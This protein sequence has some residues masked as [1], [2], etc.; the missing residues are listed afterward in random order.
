MI[1][2][3]YDKDDGTQL[4][5][6]YMHL[7]QI[8][9]KEGQVVQ[10]GQ[11]IG[12]SGNT[13]RSTGPH[14]HFET[15]IKDASGKIE[16]FNPIHYLA[17]IEGRTSN[18]TPLLR[19]GQDLLA[20]ERSKYSPAAHPISQEDKAQNLLANI[21]QSNDPTK[22]L[23]YLMSQNSENGMDNNKDAFSELISTLFSAALVMAAKIKANEMQAVVNREARLT[24]NDEEKT[25]CQL[26]KREREK[27][28]ASKLHVLASTIFETEC[29]ENKQIVGLKQA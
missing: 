6:I 17:A 20:E 2:I 15:K 13:G 19:N 5:C 16:A 18:D 12:I 1:K 27:V 9:V 10:A 23:G 4:Q 3:A 7:S 24:E 14:L 11:Q 8:N 26:V 25:E 22:W 29:P 28:D 21:T